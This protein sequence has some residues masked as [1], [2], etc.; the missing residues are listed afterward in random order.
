M[1]LS[2]LSRSLLFPRGT[3]VFLFAL[4]SISLA[5][6]IALVVYVTG[7]TRFSYLHL[8]YLPI[9]FAGVTLRLWGG[10]GIALFAGALLGPLMPEHVASQLYQS[11]TV[12]ILRTFFFTLVGVTAGLS[13]YFFR[14]YLKDL[15]ERLKLNPLTGLPNLFGFEEAVESRRGDSPKVLSGAIAVQIKRLRTIEKVIGP[16]GVDRLIQEVAKRIGRF[17]P[18]ETLI[19][20][21]DLATF[22]LY[23]EDQRDVEG[24]AEKVRQGIGSIFNVNQIPIFAEIYYGLVKGKTVRE[25]TESLVRR[26]KIAVDRAMTTGRQKAWFDENDDEIAKRNVRLIHDLQMALQEDQLFLYYQPKMDLKTGKIVGAEALVR[27]MHPKLGMISPADFIPLTENTM[28]INPFTKWL[29]TKSI[30]QLRTWLDKD[31]GL[32]LSINFSMKNF[33]D[34]SLLDDLRELMREYHIPKNALEIEVTETS[35][36]ENIMAVGDVL[37]NLRSMGLKIAVDDYGTGQSSLQYLFELPLDTIKIDRVF[38]NSLLTNSAAEAIVRSAIHLA[39]E[40]NLSVVAEGVETR[41]QL[42]KLKDLKCDQAQ[43]FYLA[44]P[45]PAEL[46]TEWII[47]KNQEIP[48]SKEAHK[49]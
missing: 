47:S 28:L 19:C 26:A 45:M 33:L 38:I 1:R 9:L 2:D 7:G 43:G 31:L 6:L 21:A 29:I 17:A 4:L 15:E 18:S 36:A 48:S 12:W 22:I 40:L 32:L 8:M 35:V 44:K 13:G 46:A 14:A 11:H 3:T 42:L 34:A 25:T 49:S 41:E 39:H 23:V 5:L 20:H 24:N 37:Q 30:R 10:V 16:K 27:W